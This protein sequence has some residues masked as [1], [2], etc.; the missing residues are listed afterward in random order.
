M[1]WPRA[2]ESGSRL[3]LSGSGLTGIKASWPV[4]RP[5]CRPRRVEVHAGVVHWQ[6]QVNIKCTSL[7]PASQSIVTDPAAGSGRRASSVKPAGSAR[8][9]FSV[10]PSC[11]SSRHAQ[12]GTHARQLSLA[13]NLTMTMAA[14]SSA[15]HE[16][17]RLIPSQAGQVSGAD[18]EL[19][20][21][22]AAHHRAMPRLVP[23]QASS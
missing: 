7:S 22:R 1:S 6:V 3:S 10:S 4:T 16:P 14:R 18:T 20:R 9:K 13:H 2:A 21:P 15:G 17:P 12:A 11:A 5:E 23:A 19:E 8:F